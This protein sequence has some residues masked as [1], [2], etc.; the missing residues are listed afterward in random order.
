M[1][2][3]VVLFLSY[4]V[5]ALTLDHTIENNW[6]GLASV[7]NFAAA[8]LSVPFL[9]VRA[10]SLRSW[11]TASWLK[12]L[13]WWLIIGFPVVFLVFWAVNIAIVGR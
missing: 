9:L 13:R 3:T 2:T 10:W 7:G 5:L 6:S 4:G 12:R 11:R 1:F 8:F